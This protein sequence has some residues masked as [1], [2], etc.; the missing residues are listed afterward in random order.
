[1]NNLVV[2]RTWKFILLK[3]K[4]NHWVTLTFQLPQKLKE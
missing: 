1:M 4:R 3:F 2:E